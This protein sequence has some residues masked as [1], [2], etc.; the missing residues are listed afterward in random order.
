MAVV[1]AP[2]VSGPITRQAL[3]AVRRLLEED[4]LGT[5]PAAAGALAVAAQIA[6]AAA[7]VATEAV[8]IT[9]ASAGTTAQLRWLVHPHGEP[10]GSCVDASIGVMH[11]YRAYPSPVASPV[12]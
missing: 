5:W 7:S 6:A 2:H 11:A 4:C 10:Q 9:P 12:A 3:G 8:A 1:T